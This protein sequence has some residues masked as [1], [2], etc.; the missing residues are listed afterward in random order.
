MP[1]RF[2][3]AVFSLDFSASGVETAFRELQIPLPPFAS[4]ALTRF[5]FQNRVFASV[6]DLMAAVAAEENPAPRV[7]IVI[8]PLPPAP[9]R[10][11][12]I[13]RLPPP[14]ALAP[15]VPR[16]PARS[17]V[18]FAT[19]IEAIDVAIHAACTLLARANVPY[20]VQGSC[21]AMMHRAIV[22]PPPGDVDILISGG[23]RPVDAA[24]SIGP[25]IT[26]ARG[27]PALVLNYACLNGVVVQCG[28]AEDF[29][30]NVATAVTICGY[31]TM[32]L[33]ETLISLLLRPSR[34]PGGNEKEI[35]AFAS[36]VLIR[37]VDLIASQQ[38][39]V[40]TFFSRAPSARPRRGMASFA[41]PGTTWDVAE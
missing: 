7:P 30:M 21:A 22:S 26:K 38:D 39:R 17:E 35:R 31:R 5:D 25:F 33:T 27:G 15:P 1:I 9:V 10:M 16:R 14:G 4:Q 8:G 32:S 28:D 11:A 36:L 19:G 20:A 29:G 3:S 2:R 12:P 34:T 24:L 6:R 18:K 41:G 13:P 23:L 37:G 40:A